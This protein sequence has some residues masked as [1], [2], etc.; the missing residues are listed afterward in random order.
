M[1]RAR[2][3]CPA[4]T[5]SAVVLLLVFVVAAPANGSFPGRNGSI[6]FTSEALDQ[7]ADFYVYFGSSGWRFSPPDGTRRMISEGS[8]AAFS[9]KGQLLAITD[10]SGRRSRGIVLRRLDGSGLSG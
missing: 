10:S 2:S 8:G 9:P 7:D 6:A 4:I 3:T 5:T 1:A